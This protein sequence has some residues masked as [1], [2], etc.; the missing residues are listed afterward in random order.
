MDSVSLC[1]T[2]IVTG[3]LSSISKTRAANVWRLHLAHIFPWTIGFVPLLQEPRA[4]LCAMKSAPKPKRGTIRA[5]LDSA[6]VFCGGAEYGSRTYSHYGPENMLKHDGN[7][8]CSRECHRRF[9]VVHDLGKPCVITGLEV[10]PSGYCNS[11][12]KTV[13]ISATHRLPGWVQ[14]VGAAQEARSADKINAEQDYTKNAQHP[15]SRLRWVEL[16]RSPYL[17][18]EVGVA[19]PLPAALCGR[20]VLFYCIAGTRDSGNI[21]IGYMQVHGR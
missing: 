5:P 1:R 18:T 11:N 20:F 6:L 10:Q 2:E 13:R 17:E 16:T 21:D 4:L 7:V 12:L 3:F 9:L 8:F 14:G 15:A 19:R